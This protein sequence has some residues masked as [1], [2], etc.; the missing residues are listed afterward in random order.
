MD[1]LS[2]VVL[3]LLGLLVLQ[4]LLTRMKNNIFKLILPG[5]TFLFSVI[6]LINLSSITDISKIEIILMSIISF[7]LCNIPTALFMLISYFIDNKKLEREISA[8]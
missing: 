4:A 7:V 2:V 5:I 1:L 8:H 6:V 3:V